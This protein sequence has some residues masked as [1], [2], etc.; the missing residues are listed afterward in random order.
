MKKLLL[1]LVAGILAA[2]SPHVVRAGEISFTTS[3]AVGE[4]IELVLFTDELP[5]ITV[6][7][8]TF[9]G[10]VK[11]QANNSVSWAWFTVESQTVKMNGHITNFSCERNSLTALDVTKCPELEYLY[12]GQ[13]RLESLDVT[14]CPALK[15]LSCDYNYYLEALDV[16]SCSG[17]KRLNCR[18]NALLNLDVTN[19]PDLDELCCDMNRIREEGAMDGLIASL[20]DRSGLEEKGILGVV[21]LSDSKE[22]NICTPQQAEAARKRGWMVK[23]WTGEHWVDYFGESTDVDE[24]TLTTSKS[25]GETIELAFPVD[26]GTLVS[27][28]GATVKEMY[29]KDGYEYIVYSLESQTVKVTGRM[30]RFICKGNS[31]TALDVT[32][33]PRLEQLYCGNNSLTALDATK[34]PRLTKLHCGNNS[35]TAL[36]VSNCSLLKMLYCGN[37]SLTALD[38]TKC[39]RLEQLYCGNNSLTALDVSNCSLLR[40]LFCG[41]NSLTALDVTNCTKLGFISCEMN[42]IKGKAMDDLVASLYDRSGL[43]KKGTL[44]VLDLSDPKEGNVCTTLQAEAARQRGWMVRARTG[45]DWM[46]YP[47]S[48]P[49]VIEDTPATGFGDVPAVIYD[50]EGRSSRELRPGIH[51]VKTKNGKAVKVMR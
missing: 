11:D 48:D 35:L 39:P 32:K 14:K 17:L 21:N 24:I 26:E 2:L 37:N 49:T 12:C 16:S 30:T 9:V 46:D 25:V 8:A 28:E 23:A 42:Q 3:K 31:L 20:C 44:N 50:L 5:G 15:C 47:G 36:D 40:M 51:I 10:S 43:E 6:E 1:F 33:C 41:N 27:V 38:V 29:N 7:G 22:L 45:E 13:N 18:G 19:C 4:T 34:C